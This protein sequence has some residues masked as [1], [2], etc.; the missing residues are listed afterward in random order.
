MKWIN[1]VKPNGF[2]YIGIL[3]MILNV[4][5]WDCSFLL[6]M[7]GSALVFFSDTITNSMNSYLKAVD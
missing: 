1:Q 2:F 3:I 5:F 4:V 6:M 7:I